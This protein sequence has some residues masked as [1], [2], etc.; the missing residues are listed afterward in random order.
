MA[1]SRRGRSSPCPRSPSGPRGPSRGGTGVP[2]VEKGP[3]AAAPSV[4]AIRSALAGVEDPEIHRPITELGMV[5]D[6][7]VL[8]HGKVEIGVYLTVAGCPM[9]ETITSRVTTAVS[10]V[11]GV[12]SVQVAL[13]VMSDE[14]RAELRR[15]ARGTD[16]ADPVIPFAQ[17]GSL[18]RVYAVASG[19]GGVGKSSVTV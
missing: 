19:K 2:R 1:V 12:T 6:I 14:R 4:D 17:P 15:T 16:A 10:A 8:D 5:K 7:N 9:K 3:M 11:P 13:D 18:T